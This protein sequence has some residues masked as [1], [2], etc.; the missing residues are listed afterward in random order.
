MKSSSVRGTPYTHIASPSANQGFRQ[1]GGNADNTVAEQ[2]RGG[3]INTQA[4]TR[5]TPAN[6]A[7]GNPDETRRVVSS[8]RYGKV[9]SGSQGNAND[10]KNN[11]DGVVLD[12][13]GK[14]Y[15]SPGAAPSLDSPVPGN[16]PVFDTAS[17][18]AE[19]RAHLGSNMP[20]AAS[21]DDILNLG[22]VLSRG[23]KGTSTSG[24]PETELTED[25]TLPAVAP[26][27]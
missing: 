23:M 14:D 15:A 20:E 7:H 17:I 24:G 12:R 3:G 26:A 1:G 16:A 6:Y 2:F 9:E 22:G 25:D 4:N 27:R 11:G 21:R 10:P 8:D 19:N 5:G 13:M 18:L